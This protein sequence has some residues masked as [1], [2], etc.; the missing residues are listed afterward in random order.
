MTREQAKRIALK[1]CKLSYDEQFAR[2]VL[3]VIRNMPATP[4]LIGQLIAVQPMQDGRR[5]HT[6]YMDFV[7]DSWWERFKR[8]LMSF[9]R[10]RRRR[11]VCAH[12][13]PLNPWPRA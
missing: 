8:W 1:Q 10:V 7:R 13:E 11:R 6:F 9:F 3:P 4:D 12:V 5:V 2:W